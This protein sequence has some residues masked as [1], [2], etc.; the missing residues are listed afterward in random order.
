R[1]SSKFRGVPFWAWN[2]KVTKEKIDTQVEAFHRMGMG[3]AMVHPRTGMDTPYLSEEYMALVK[4]A[5]EKLRFNGM[6]CWLYDEERFPSGCAGGI[7]TRCLAYRSRV[8]VVSKDVPEGIC[9]SKAEFDERVAGGEKPRGY[10]LC[11]YDINL[12]DGYLKSYA[13]SESGA[14]HA[15]VELMQESGWF[16]GETYSDVF[17]PDATDEFLR[18]THEKYYEALKEHI[19]G[20]V[21]A[22]FT[23]E[24]HM[25]GK[26]CLPFPTSS[27]AT[28]AFSEGINQ[29]FKSLWGKSIV[30]IA[31]E[32]IWELS[33]GYSTWR[34]RYHDFVTE[35]FARNYGD[36]IGAWCEKHGIAYTGHFL[37]ERTLFSQTLALGETMRQYR[38]QQLPGVDILANQFELT[39]VKQAESVRRQLGREGLVCEMYGVLEWD[40][41]FLEHKLQGDWLA[42]LGVTTRVH[43]LTFMSMGGEAKR[44][45][46]ASI[47]PQSPWWEYYE[48]LETYFA[49]INALLTRGHAIT[50]VAVLHPIESF[51]LRFGP[52]SQTLSERE[53]MDEQ[54]ENLTQWLLYGLIDYDYL[55]EAMLPGLAKAEK[56]LLR[57]GEAAYAV[58]LIPEILTV[59]K[60]T[61]DILNAF[62]DAGGRIIALGDAPRYVDGVR[63]EE[64]IAVWNKAIR[65]KNNRVSVLEAL[66]GERDIDIRALNSGRRSDNLIYNYRQDE[67]ERTLFIAHVRDEKSS[68]C[69]DYE[70]SVRG[71]WKPT[72][73]D[74]AS[75]ETSP[76]SFQQE[77]GC[78][79]IFWRAYCHDSLLLRL[80]PEEAAGCELSKNAVKPFQ[81]FSVPQSVRLHEP[82]ALLLDRARYALDD[83]AL[84]EA[85]EDILRADNALRQAA[86]LPRRDGDQVQPWLTPKE[87]ARHTVRL[88]YTFYAEKAFDGLCLAMEQPENA[89]ICLNGKSVSNKA[90]G[91]YVDEDIKTLRL[92]AVNEGVNHLEI[93]VPLTRRTNLESMYILGN[94][95]VDARGTA[96]TMTELNQSFQLDD[97]TRQ[98]LPFYTG[99]ISYCFKFR[100]D[101][102]KALTLG[103]KHVAAPVVSV[104]LDGKDMG[105]VYMQPWQLA[106]GQLDAG[107]HELEIITCG[108]RYNGFGS[109][110]NANPDYKWYGPNAYR[111]TGDEWTDNYL[112]RPGYLCGPVELLEDVK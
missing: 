86:G 15:Y 80:R 105:I 106:L 9:Q 73:L 28:V 69:A 58:V 55:S 36:R 38:A 54:F 66:R 67:S 76:I 40:V 30:E 104:K 11:S 34:Y 20:T 92:P 72:V 78:T 79:R 23:D 59:R 31:P 46:P 93:T 53:Q 65:V 8:L 7:V 45:W 62:A 4:H 111:T 25:K 19:G 26:Y 37:S 33:D 14:W 56:G 70:I 51:W 35:R 21:P 10:R 84:S 52:N 57:A 74:A 48:P 24:P 63:S 17:N 107:E 98:G 41:S 43:H 96:L 81:R 82:N 49:R 83:S 29:E 3:G 99:N 85:A 75:G 94:F 97:M 103:L 89:V 60:S 18:V 91:W 5:E 1:P 47:G 112:V 12:E 109:L 16:N 2:C 64:A 13:V 87:E 32:L 90:I 6:D 68:K 102:A 100:L 108:T 71:L 101:S 110:H 27:R 22:I 77:G 50:R 95:G 61:L 39:T 42:A 44:D 88:R